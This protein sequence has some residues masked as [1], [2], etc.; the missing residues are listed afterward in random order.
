[1]HESFGVNAYFEVFSE[2]GDVL[3][4]I[5]PVAEFGDSGVALG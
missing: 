4:K 3:A 5:E 2:D 1:L